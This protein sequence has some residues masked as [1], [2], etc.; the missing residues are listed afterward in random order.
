MPETRWLRRVSKSFSD[1]PLTSKVLLGHGL[2]DALFPNPMTAAPLFRV[3][4]LQHRSKKKRG[5]AWFF[6]MCGM[7]KVRSAIAN[8]EMACHLGGCA[9]MWQ[10]IAMSVEGF[11][12]H[13]IPRPTKVLASTIGFCA[14][15]FVWLQARAWRSP[16]LSLEIAQH[17]PGTLPS[18]PLTRTNEEDD[19]VL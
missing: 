3:L 2:L 5:W 1:L 18:A 8:E 12:H 14:A 6:L 9:Y 7:M 11:Y 10:A 19:I 4:D 16:S 13:S 15:M 17:E